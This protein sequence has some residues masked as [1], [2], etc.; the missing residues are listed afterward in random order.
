MYLG[1]DIPDHNG[2]VG[3][4]SIGVLPSTSIAFKYLKSVHFGRL[5]AQSH[6]YNGKWVSL[7]SMGFTAPS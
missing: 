7:C 4:G 6:A 5:A 1:D 2:S 3:K